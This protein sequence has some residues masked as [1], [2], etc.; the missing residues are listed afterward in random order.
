MGINAA[1]VPHWD[2]NE[3]SGH[4]T[5]YCFLGERRFARL[6]REIPDDTFV[7]GIDEHTALVIDLDTRHAT[8]HGRSSVTIRQGGHETVFRSGADVPIDELSNVATPHA[9]STQ[10]SG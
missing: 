10:A 3:G 6:E 8:V 5:R 7:L 4:D 2:N 9:M 1:V